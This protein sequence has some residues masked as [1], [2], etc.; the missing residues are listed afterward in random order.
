M[1]ES[2]CFFN[3]RALYIQY[4]KK[5]IVTYVSAIFLQKL[6]VSAHKFKSLPVKNFVDIESLDWKTHGGIFKTWS[7]SHSAS[8][9]ITRSQVS[10]ILVLNQIE[11]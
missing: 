2:S 3:T 11:T 1:E 5:L 8:K 6:R 10:A 4:C 7:T 9:K